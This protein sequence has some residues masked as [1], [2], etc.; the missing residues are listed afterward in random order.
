MINANSNTSTYPDCAAGS[1]A[2]VI[3]LPAGTI[4]MAIAG[5]VE[6]V[7][8]TGDLD[9]Y[10]SVTINGHPS[11]TT[12]DG[13]D[14]DRI[15]DINSTLFSLIPP[16]LPITVGLH[17]LNIVN[18][19]TV[20]DGGGVSVYRFATVT[21]TDT[22]IADCRTNNDAGGLSITSDAAATLINVTVTGNACPWLA[23]G[24]RTDSPITMKSCTITNNHT[25]GGTPTRGQGIGSYA[26]T[27]MQNTLV[28]GN[29]SAPGQPDTEG[30]FTSLGHNIIGNIDLIT[31]ITPATGD[32]F[33]VTTAQVN[34]APLANNGG[35]VRTH[36]LNAGSVAVDKGNSDGVTT[37]ARG[38]ARPCDQPAIANAAGGDGADI[39]A[40]EVQGTC[41]AA[42]VAPEAVDDLASVAED[43][44]G[45]IIDVL[46][47]D[48]DANGDT[49][50]ITAVAQGANG[51]TVNNGTDLSYTP[52]PDFA[53]NDFFTYTVT[54]GNG[55]FSTAVVYVTVTPVNDPPV[56]TGENY[57]I[58]QDT[59]LNVAA[60]DVLANDTD[61]DGDV[62]TAINYTAPA[63]GT[64]AG[65][66]NGSFTYTPNPGFAGTDSFTYCV[67][68][69]IAPCVPAT[70]NITVNDTQGPDI[71][72]SLGTAL[73]WPP[74]HALINV[75]FSVSATDNGGG[76]VTLG[77]AVFSDEDDVAPN[78]GG[79]SPDAVD[80]APATLRLRSERDATSDG[81]V[82]L[83]IVTASDGSS[84][85]STSCLTAVVPKSMSPANVNSVNAQAS[86]AAAQCQATGMAPAGWFPIGE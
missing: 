25:F 78:N 17:G 22:T 35:P 33:G 68:D 52:D 75:G 72:A 5:I 18:G 38:D 44:A 7:A 1:G 54:D 51:T 24:I 59:V 26:N 60:P 47:N 71:T 61:A 77:Y 23:A 42:N 30:F 86:A 2:D 3:N 49:L 12:I 37:D 69:G 55:E 29:G 67:F 83:V 53:G 56:A 58:N 21:I 20:G 74:N 27:T 80:I 10:D 85:T 63:N 81:R 79:P 48:S 14:L 62:L 82:Y 6:D 15:F 16:G 64:L 73:L 34:L 84:N 66:T 28:A 46:A 43:S 76:A 41:S 8:A 40:F 4:T 19:T 13:N 11:G 32:Q 57:V 39:G 9:L 45:N 65:N 31:T 70:V 50:T 36:A